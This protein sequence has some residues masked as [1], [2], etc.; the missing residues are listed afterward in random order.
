MCVQ[1]AGGR[2]CR[3][4]RTPA[5]SGDDLVRDDEQDRDGARGVGG[6]VVSPA[7]SGLGD[8]LFGCGS[9]EV[10]RVVGWAGLTGS[11]APVGSETVAL[12]IL[13]LPRQDA[14]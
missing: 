12:R 6:E 10:T 1:V 9:L 8:K 11:P 13:P 14:R 7:S 2:P 5:S 3:G 4:V